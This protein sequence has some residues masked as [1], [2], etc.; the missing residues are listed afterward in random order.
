MAV[1]KAIGLEFAD[2]AYSLSEVR[3]AL[4]KAERP[5]QLSIIFCVCRSAKAEGSLHGSFP[6]LRSVGF[7]DFDVPFA[8]GL[9]FLRHWIGGLDGSRALS[10]AH[11][12]ALQIFTS[13]EGA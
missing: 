9:L 4:E 5:D 11:Q 8:E 7:A 13:E 6:V 3:V 2:G 12:H 10:D 1:N